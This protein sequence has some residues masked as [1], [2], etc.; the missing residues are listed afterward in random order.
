M[1]SISLLIWA[2]DIA[3]KAS[4]TFLTLTVFAGI[5]FICLSVA[6]FF[7]DEK[8]SGAGYWNPETQKFC[9]T[10]AGYTAKE[11]ESFL[12]FR[13][14]PVKFYYLDNRFRWVTLAGVL[15]VF[16]GMSY[17]LLPSRTTLLT[18]GASEAVEEFSKT[19]AAGD[20]GEIATDL[21]SILKREV[22]EIAAPKE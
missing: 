7:Y 2:A 12:L 5:A 22:K 17:I 8:P 3:E 9:S 18:I 21:L 13:D 20:I 14:V 11:L 6:S 16:F 4:S 1:N 19:P 15:W 10:R